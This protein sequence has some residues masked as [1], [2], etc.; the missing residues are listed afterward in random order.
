[1]TMKQK[2]KKSWLYRAI[3]IPAVL[4]LIGVLTAAGGVGYFH[5]APP[6]RT[7]LSCHEIQVSYDSWRASAHRDVLCRECHGG[8]LSSGFHGLKEH[9]RQA[10]RHFTREDFD[11][12]A[13][14]EKQTVD[15]IG[16]CRR[17][18]E[19]EYAGWLESG[20]SANYEDIFLNVA[21]NRME[22]LI[23]DCFRCHGMYFEGRI[24]DL[25]EPLD[26]EGPWKLKQAELAK[27][28]TMPCMCCHEVHQEGRP[29]KRP[30]QYTQSML[31]AM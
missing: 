26:R 24:D 31:N 11:G 20:H 12:I 29:A 5:F 18:H 16:E 9:A 22:Q 13:M 8:T 1:D 27:R 3:Q 21:H 6:E 15:M 4:L 25:V 23:P 30:S 2:K 7:C 28:P 17:C 10:V 19:S 14:S